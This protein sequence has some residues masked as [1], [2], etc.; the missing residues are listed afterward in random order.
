M[1]VN[2]PVDPKTR[3]A[4]IENK[5]RLFGIYNAFA[6][7]K[8][9][10]NQQIDIALNSLLESKSLSSPS[11]KLSDEGKHLIEDL[12]EVIAEAKALILSKNHDQAIQEFIW[13]AQQAGKT[14]SGPSPNAPVTQEQAKQDGQNALAGLRSLG[15]L[16]ITNGQFRKLLNDATVMLRDI[17]SDVA[18]KAG[19]RLQPSQEQLSQIDRPAEDNTWHEAPNFSR[20]NLQ[21]RAKGAFNKNAPVNT[22]DVKQTVG[23]AT[24]AAH[25]QGSR[26]PH[27][28]GQTAAQEPQHGTSTGIDI[29]GGANHTLNRLDERKDDQKFQ[30]QK[31]KANEKSNEY[32]RRT[33]DYLKGKVPQERRD[34]TIYRLKKMV[35]EIQGHEDYQQ[36]IDTLLYLAE[37]YAGHTKNVGKQ[38]NQSVGAVRDD[39]HLQTAESLLRTLLER[40]ANNT[41]SEDLF[42]AINHIYK[43]ADQDPQLKD[44]FKHV[45]AY[46]RR[47]LKE[48][49]FI[50]SD[51][52]N[53]EYNNLYDRGRFL[54][55]E[56]YRD[57]TDRIVDE[58]KFLGDQFAQDPQN[59]RFGNSVTKLLNDLGKDENGKAV[60]KKHL[61]TD[62]SSVII[63]GFFESVR[64]IPVP[65]IEYTDNQVDVIVENLIIEGDNL[66]PNSLEFGNDSYFRWGRKTTTSKNKQRIMLSVSGIQCD[67]RD[68]SFY[69]KKKQGFPSLTD[70]G[71]M[72]IFL[73]GEGFS[74]TIK[75]SSAEKNDRANFFQIDKVDVNVKNMNIKLKKSKHK[76]LFA[77]FKPLLLKIVRP[78]LQKV[79]EK[80]IKTSFTD[81]DRRLFA[82]KS[83]ADKVEED[84]KQNPDPEKAQSIF[85]RY[86][87]AAQHEFTQKK[88]KAKEMTA[89]KKANIALTKE[90]SIFKNI[91]LPSG[92]STA[93]TKYKNMAREGERWESP[94][95]SIGSA[96]QS[97]NL[98]KPTEVT[99]KSHGTGRAQLRSQRDS[100][101]DFETTGINYDVSG[102]DPG[103]THT[104]PYAQL[105]QSNKAG[106]VNPQM[107]GNNVRATLGH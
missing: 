22:E 100:G 51:E 43:D 64:Y 5:L 75:M 77:L 56:R 91:D 99:R 14:S 8:V 67:L 38:T 26:D 25:P 52:A 62:I 55:R 107:L 66:M 80:Q 74:F 96:K 69:I 47:C 6:N 61:L 73:G 33:Q 89:D 23:D 45:D 83:E 53:D 10:S 41:S 76:L 35:V 92:T 44:W 95:F 12:R 106:N 70:T 34:Q 98:P 40:F 90:D 28:L 7:G 63:P 18:Q 82:I 79:L 86:L 102:F 11:G 37:T 60:F 68:V 9:P 58:L 17:A 4:D 49:G 31:D 59:A 87:S 101:M 103:A 32:K 30:E 105:P 39:N 15:T 94:V 24:S 16:I 13:H 48:Q 81:L 42:E 72:D 97:S 2:R 29:Q 93:A 78:A 20:G 104:G 36:A 46:I 50:L 1:S 65:R 84:L 57:H 54:L 19:G 71:L 27:A 88:E 3:D 85:Q 21:E